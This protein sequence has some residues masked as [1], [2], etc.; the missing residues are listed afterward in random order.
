MGT[1]EHIDD[2]DHWDEMVNINTEQP[3]IFDILLTPPNFVE[4]AERSA[5][6]T[7]CDAEKISHLLSSWARIL[8]NW[9]FQ[10]FLWAAELRITK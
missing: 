1:N 9:H 2:E 10:I 4:D 5:V 8:M 7:F 6:C 3:G